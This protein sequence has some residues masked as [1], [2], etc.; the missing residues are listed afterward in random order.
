MSHKSYNYRAAIVAD[1]EAHR[2]QQLRRRELLGEMGAARREDLEPVGARDVRAL[3]G[4]HQG[5]RECK[6]CFRTGPKGRPG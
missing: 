6:S 5:K 2:A 3:E 4:L 1:G